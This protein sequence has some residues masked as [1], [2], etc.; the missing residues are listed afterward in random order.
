MTVDEIEQRLSAESTR[1]TGFTTCVYNGVL[2]TYMICLEDGVPR[3]SASVTVNDDLSVC[4]SVDGQHTPS[5]QYSDIVSSSL[6]TMSQFI[7][8]MARVKS[9]VEEPQAKDADFFIQTAMNS[10]E[11]SKNHFDDDDEKSRIVSFSIEQLQL[12]ST[13]KYGRHYS[14]EL[15]IFTYVVHATSAAA[16]QVLLDQKLLCLLSVSTLKKITRRLDSN[17]GL[18]NS[19]YLTLRASKLNEQQR[20]VVLM[21]D[22]IYVAKRVPDKWL[23]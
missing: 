14:P 15:N 4:V 21:I 17:N 5:S 18:D 11:S 23:A 10:L 16:Y 19:A 7:N 22:E 6:K 3:I 13:T 1:P 2:L 9:W 20:T 8:L 12:L